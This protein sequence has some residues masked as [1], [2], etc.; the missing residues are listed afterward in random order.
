MLKVNE[1]FVGIQGEGLNIGMPQLF[2]RFW[3]CNLRCSWCDTPYSYEP[4]G[5]LDEEA[6]KMWRF[7]AYQEYSVKELFEEISKIS[8][9]KAVCITGGEPLVQPRDELRE[10]LRLL[11][12]YGY[13]RHLFTNGT[14]Y[15]ED[16]FEECN[17]ISMDM[18]PPSSKMK[19]EIGCLRN[20]N[21]RYDNG[22][23]CEVKVVI[24]DLD[25]FVFA[26]KHVIPIARMPVILQPEGKEDSILS[27]K[28]IQ[29][30]KNWVLSQELN[31][32]RVLPQLHKLYGW[33]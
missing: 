27:G 10:L 26:L 13:Y 31:N 18:K 5:Y 12:D 15:D 21:L 29:Q 3:G 25:D 32:V 4:K 23:Q 11:G 30:I 17:F 7:S 2:I 28:L 33:K 1:I 24:K 20:L 8:T 6:V 9:L 19:S 22:F 16:I 14:I